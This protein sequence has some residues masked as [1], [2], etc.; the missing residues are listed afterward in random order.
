MKIMGFTYHR[1]RKQILL[2]GDSALLVNRKPFFVPDSTSHVAGYPALALRVCR[3]GKNIDARF[4]SRYYDAVALALDIQAHDLRA[5]ASS[6]G[7]PWTTAVSL[8]GSFP[9]GEFREVEGEEGF[10]RVQKGL[11]RLRGVE[12]GE[13][14]FREVQRGLERFRGVYSIGV[15]SLT[16]EATA[17]Q[18]AEVVS[19]VSKYMTIRQGD[20]IYLPLT[21]EPI[22]LKIDDTIVA[23]FEGE[24]EQN[25]FCRIK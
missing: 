5:Q 12:K 17:E 23:G 25:L 3:L 1:G 2:K 18:M 7:L 4:A 24:E 16:Y 15:A 21:E 22:P 13:E 9:V 10:R 14:V 11:E 20:I 19:L 8:D 6:E